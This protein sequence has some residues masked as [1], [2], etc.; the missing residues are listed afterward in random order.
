VTK[1]RGTDVIGDIGLC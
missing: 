1:G